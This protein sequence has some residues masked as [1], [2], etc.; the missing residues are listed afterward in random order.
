MRESVF[1]ERS[2]AWIKANKDMPNMAVERVVEIYVNLKYQNL[3]CFLNIPF[4][5]F[6]I[7]IFYTFLIPKILVL[8]SF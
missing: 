6:K 1:R 8:Y 3:E 5:N 4:L 2:D 7:R